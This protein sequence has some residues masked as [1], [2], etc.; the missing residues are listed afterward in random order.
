MCVRVL[1]SCYFSLFGISFVDEFCWRFTDEFGLC[2]Y[3]LM[4]GF[5]VLTMFGCLTFCLRVLACLGAS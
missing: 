4:I 2:Y 1:G 5:V 3:T